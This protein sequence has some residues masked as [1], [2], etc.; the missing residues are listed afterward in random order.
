MKKWFLHVTGPFFLCGSA[1]FG[2]PCVAGSLL[3][4]IILGVT[5]CSVEASIIQ[6]SL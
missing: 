4:Y 1:L 2:A 3:S 5:G 6:R